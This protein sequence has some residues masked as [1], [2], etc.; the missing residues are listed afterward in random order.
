[1]SRNCAFVY[2]EQFLQYKFH[3]DHPFNQLRVKM[4][5]DLL[6]TLGALEDRQIVAPRMATDDELALI[7]DRSYIEAV[8]A[9]GRGELSEAA[10]QNYGLGTEDTPIFPNM[11]ESSALLVGSTLTAVD[12][13]LSGAAEHALN[14]GGGLHHGF[15][16]K[17]SGFCVYNDSAVAIQ[18]IRE[19]Y[20]LRVLYV[21]TDAH[22]GDG[23]QW[24]FYDDPNVC[25]FSIHETGRYLFP[26]TGNVNE[27]GLGAG[28]G[29]SFNIP[30][31]AFTEDESWIAAYTTALREIAD[32]FRPDVIVTQNGVDAHYY[33]PLTHLSVTM[34]TYRA[35]PKLAH[36]IAHEYCGGRWI[37][38]GGGG[39]D[40]WRVVPRAWALLWLEMTGQADV[41][42][43]LPDEWRE[44]WQPLSP[45]ALPLEWDD[46]D[47]LYPPIPR[48][49]EISE[50]NAQ[51]VEKALYFIRS[52][53]PAR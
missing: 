17:A 23:V 20:G 48:K 24:A 40:I 50:K 8:K 41:S 10:A 6:C 49:A 37:A 7:H 18:Y 38:V 39:Y 3:D 11:H 27:R 32:F 31:D 44:R 36:E 53:R 30:V 42:G 12:A 46:P 22:H 35:I 52:Q 16:G 33:D 4:T 45:V 26:G 29:Y 14:L 34:K 13:V 15:R 9:A 43:P 19:K 47:D 51:T 21:D 28:Y 1:M 25:T 2:S 5:Y